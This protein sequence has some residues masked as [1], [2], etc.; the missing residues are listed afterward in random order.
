MLRRESSSG[1]S[2]LC[3]FANAYARVFACSLNAGLYSP[4]YAICLLLLERRGTLYVL[5]SRHSEFHFKVN[6]DINCQRF[7][8]FPVII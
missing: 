3:G 6:A 4:K 2:F 5:V 7:M 1:S 8:M